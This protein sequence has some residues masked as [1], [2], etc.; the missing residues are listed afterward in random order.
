[1]QAQRDL[2]DEMEDIARELEPISENLGNAS[3]YV[4]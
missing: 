1:M 3:L 2:E 4:H